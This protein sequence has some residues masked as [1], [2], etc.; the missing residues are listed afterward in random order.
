MAARAVVFP[1]HG[2]PVSKMR[3]TFTLSSWMA[4]ALGLEDDVAEMGYEM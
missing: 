3:V 2:P 1:A 4:P